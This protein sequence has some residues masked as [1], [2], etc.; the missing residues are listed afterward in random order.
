LSNEVNLANNQ[1][2]ETRTGVNLPDLV[3]EKFG[4]E[5]ALHGSPV[6]YTLHYTN[7][8]AHAAGPVVI[9]DLLPGLLVTPTYHASG[10]ALTLQPGAPF[11]WRIATLAPGETIPITLTMDGFTKDDDRA[12][13]RW[14][15]TAIKTKQ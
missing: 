2:N 15:V 7:V 11:T 5:S 14:K 3:I 8:G 10:P 9:L 6:T 13:I 12:N 4:P 1:S